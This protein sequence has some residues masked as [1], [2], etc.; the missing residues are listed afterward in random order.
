MYLEHKPK[1]K[2]KSMRLNS[3]HVRTIDDLFRRFQNFRSYPQ[4]LRRRKN[5][6]LQGS[7]VSY[8]PMAM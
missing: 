6:L 7:S 2:L 8:C 4:F 1:E 3:D 5:N